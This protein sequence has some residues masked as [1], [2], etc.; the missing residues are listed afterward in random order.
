MRWEGEGRTQWD[1]SRSPRETANRLDH[2]PT[3]PHG[4]VSSCSVSLLS[5]FHYETP[6]AVR[7]GRW[8]IETE[9]GSR[10][11]SP[12]PTGHPTTDYSPVPALPLTSPSRYAPVSRSFFPR[13]LRVPLGEVEEVTRW[14]TE[15]SEGTNRG[16]DDTRRAGEGARWA[17]C[18]S[19]SVCLSR[20]HVALAPRSFLPSSVPPSRR[21]LGPYVPLS[22]RALLHSV[23]SERPKGVERG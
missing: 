19:L 14:E 18:H 15:R 6:P 21:S 22:L 1:K 2:L 10:V 13:S 16:T 11:L 20:H 12:Y 17:T 23:P 5:P 7:N 4:V 8:V 9:P 3:S